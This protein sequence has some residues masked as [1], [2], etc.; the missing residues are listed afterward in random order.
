M[1]ISL[2][3]VISVIVRLHLYSFS[4]SYSSIYSY[5]VLHHDHFLLLLD[6]YLYYS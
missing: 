1:G 4:L 3:Q 2:L 5:F 6:D